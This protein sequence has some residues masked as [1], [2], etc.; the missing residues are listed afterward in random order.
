MAEH[1]TSGKRH[2]LAPAHP[3]RG[4]RLRCGP[5]L[6]GLA[7]FTLLGF[8]V[9]SSFCMQLRVMA[10]PLGVQWVSPG[11]SVLR[12]PVAAGTQ[13]CVT[14]SNSSCRLLSPSPRAEQRSERFRCIG[15]FNTGC[16]GNK[17][18]VYPRCKERETEA[19]RGGGAGGRTTA[20]KWRSWLEISSPGRLAA[21]LC[22]SRSLGSTYELWRLQSRHAGPPSPAPVS[23]APVS[24]AA[25]L[26]LAGERAWITA[27]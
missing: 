22:Q 15:S 13:Q 1:R 24:P 27:A 11:G 23:P 25:T 16:L 26:H 4:S 9:L 20:N 14:A 8:S 10:I 2:Q 19:Q 7:Y 17:Y 6:A 12:A 21:G 3:P 5:F 18:V